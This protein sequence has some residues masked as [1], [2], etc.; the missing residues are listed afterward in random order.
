MPLTG[1]QIQSQLI[2]LLTL[3]IM[4][5]LVIIPPIQN[6]YHTVVQCKMWSC[7]VELFRNVNW[8]PQKIS[9]ILN[10]YSLLKYGV[11]IWCLTPL[12]TI[13]QFY[14]GGQNIDRLQVLF[15]CTTVL[16]EYKSRK[17]YVN[18]VFDNTRVRININR[19]FY[20]GIIYIGNEGRHVRISIRTFK[21]LSSWFYRNIGEDSSGL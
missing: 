2:Y 16:Y 21:A 12:S 15:V 17:N 9:N 1:D 7:N 19:E 11:W 6:K 5:Y 4:Y 14:R 3:V 20:H 18:N 10:V 8:P 13:F